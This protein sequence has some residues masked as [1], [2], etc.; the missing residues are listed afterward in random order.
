MPRTIFCSYL[1]R[2][3]EGLDRIPYP[4][5]L[6]QRIY[7]NISKEAWQQWVRHQTMLL[8]EYRL[9]PIDPKARKFLVEEMEKFLFGGGAQKPEGYVSPDA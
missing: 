6:G 9:S 5:E 7:E 1:Q 8:N 3:A 4:G 2:E